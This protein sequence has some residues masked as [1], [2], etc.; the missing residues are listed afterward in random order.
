MSP[1]LLKYSK[2]PEALIQ[3]AQPAIDALIKAADVKV[4][5]GQFII[6]EP[7]K[8]IFSLINIS[9]AQNQMEGQ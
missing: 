1:A 2:P 9:S 4:K 6:G 3:K 8:D 5:E 7:I